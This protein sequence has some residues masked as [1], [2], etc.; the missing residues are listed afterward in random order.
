MLELGAGADYD[1]QFYMNNGLNVVA[2][3]LSS[4]MA[5][6]CREKSVEAYELDFYNLSSLDR[7]FDCVYAINTLLHVPKNDLYHVLNEINLVLMLI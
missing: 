2:V 1:S 6:N 7:K 4:E 5:K 3:D